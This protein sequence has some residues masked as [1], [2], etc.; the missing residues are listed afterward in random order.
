MVHKAVVVAAGYGSRFFPVTRCVP[1]E[2]LPLGTRPVDAKLRE[3]R[4]RHADLL[5]LIVF[6]G[7]ATAL[8]GVAKAALELYAADLETCTGHHT[9]I[10][11]WTNTPK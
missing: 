10:D 6:R 1:K 2:M 8:N 7:T 5:E 3:T 9:S 11:S 4:P